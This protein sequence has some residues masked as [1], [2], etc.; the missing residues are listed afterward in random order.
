[1]PQDFE[2]D[3]LT[4]NR[5]IYEHLGFSSNIFLKHDNLHV[6][7]IIFDHIYVVEAIYI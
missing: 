5:L 1:M 7:N 6:K 2:M 3:I 4:Y